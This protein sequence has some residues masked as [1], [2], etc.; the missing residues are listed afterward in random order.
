[1]KTKFLLFLFLLFSSVT[2]LYAD[3]LQLNAIKLKDLSS[4]QKKY[5][6]QDLHIFVK[7]Y[8]QSKKSNHKK[9][10]SFS[11]EEFLSYLKLPGNYLLLEL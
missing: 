8:E 4:L 6:L 11:A 10:S 5:L 7:T 3:N 1:M 9:Y 2:N